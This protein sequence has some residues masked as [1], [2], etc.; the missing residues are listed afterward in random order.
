MKT[1]TALVLGLACMCTP[2]QASLTL[3]TGLGTTHTGNMVANGSFESGAPTPDG[4]RYYW[5]TGT[6]NTPF[7][8]PIGWSSSGA[9]ETYASWGNDGAG[10]ARINGSDVFP[11]GRNGLY[12]GNLF[13]TMDQQPTFHSDGKVTFTPPPTFVPDYGAPAILTQTIPTNTSP[14]SSFKFSFWA[15][16]ENASLNS[17]SEGIFGLRVTN[18]LPGDPIQY[19]TAPGGTGLLGQ[20]HLYEYSFS[21]LIPTAPVTIEFINWGH[22][23]GVHS[24]GFATELVLDDVIINEVPAPGPLAAAPAVLAI[25]A[26]RRRPA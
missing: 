22:W 23:K 3:T 14:A 26:R 24:T 5:A 19:L 10:P 16:G 6:T 12:F 7:A 18:V 17:W 4:A 13:A 2:A 1:A 9:A 11:D 25:L 21:P 20:S 8:V 15:S